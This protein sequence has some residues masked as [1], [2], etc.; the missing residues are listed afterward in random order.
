M[1]LAGAPVSSGSGDERSE[2]LSEELFQRLD[3]SVARLW[4]DAKRCP[5]WRHVVSKGF[6]PD[7]YRLVMLQIFHYT[8]HNAINQAAAA[9][10]ASPDDRP[11][12]RFVYNHAREELGHERLIVHDL[13][14]IGLLRREAIED[15]PL[16]A[17]DALIHY[18]YGVALR[19]GA[20]PRLGYSYWAESVYQH[21]GP[22]LLAARDSLALTRDN[23]TFFSVH[24]EID[25]RH[26]EEVKT[27]IR[28]A[29][30]TPQQAANVH[31][32]AV[33]SLWLTIQLLE[34]AFQSSGERRGGCL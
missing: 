28:R 27:A 23:M 33:T 9:F 30:K 12:L 26:A 6:D 29:V 17:T 5:F 24:A 20:V 13:R 34:Q 32:V 3:E 4:A 14:S 8:R 21:I 7:L 1:N 15:A 10:R 11:L 18:L 31:R 16:P 19:E 2:A 22:L 25:I